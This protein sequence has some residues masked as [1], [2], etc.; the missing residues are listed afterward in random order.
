MLGWAIPPKTLASRN[1][2]TSLAS[3]VAFQKLSM[4]PIFI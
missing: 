1:Y 3:L 4:S 2:Q